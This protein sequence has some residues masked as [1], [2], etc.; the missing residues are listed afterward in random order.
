L[1]T[2]YWS[3]LQ[4]ANGVLAFDLLKVSDGYAVQKSMYFIP[5][6]VVIGMIV[7]PMVRTPLSPAQCAQTLH[8]M[9]RVADTSRVLFPP[10]VLPKP[11]RQARAEAAADKAKK[12]E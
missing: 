9:W 11:M 5:H 7:L 6:L 8:L 1:V 3:P 4:L 10:Q 2:P 12:T